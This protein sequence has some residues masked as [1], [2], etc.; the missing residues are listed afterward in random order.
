[1]Q[2]K[3]LNKIKAAYN[4]AEKS[5]DDSLF[6]VKYIIRP[7]SFYL[8]VFFVQLRFSANQVTILSLF[9][10][11]IG[12]VMLAMGYISSLVGCILLITWLILDHV[13]GN[14]ARYYQTFSNY[15]DFLDTLTC[16]TILSFFPLGV[17]I[18]YFIH[19][20]DN[21]S[22]FILLAGFFSSLFNIFPRLLY[23]KMKN[24]NQD[25]SSYQKKLSLSPSNKSLS[26]L[27]INGASN[28]VNPSGF[29]FL[30][31]FFFTILKLSHVFLIGYFL[32]I[33][34]GM[35]YS[36]KKILLSLKHQTND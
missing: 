8:S 25:N 26:A 24:Y 6:L 36:I 13:D 22:F 10:G 30:I 28:I 14:L 16:Y 19:H 29:L 31:L 17:G 5:D 32:L 23:Q 33:L 35:L 11:I 9:I 3:L 4:P 18:G 27:L 21:I 1:M 20:D 15:G 34:V 2:K 12:T 7:L